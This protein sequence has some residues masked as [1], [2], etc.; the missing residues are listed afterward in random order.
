MQLNLVDLK[1]LGLE[2]LFRI[3]SSSIYR[4][5]DIKY[6]TPQNVYYQFFLLSNIRVACVKETSQ[7]DISFTHAKHMLFC[8]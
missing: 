5:V 1:S 2:I 3:I 4:E 6:I 7:G 8:Y